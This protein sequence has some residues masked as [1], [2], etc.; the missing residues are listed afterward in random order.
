MYDVFLSYRRDSSSEFASFLCLEL[1]RL[2][3]SVFFDSQSL[4]EG[5]FEKHITAAIEECTFFLLL[6][7]PHDLD[8]CLENPESDWILKESKKAME[9]GKVF[10][11]VQVKK[12]FEFPMNTDNSIIKFISEQ[13]ICDL[14]GTHAAEKIT[15]TLLTFMNDYPAKQLTEEYNATIVTQEYIDWELDTLK[16]IYNDIEFIYAFGRHY[17]SF[18]IEGSKSITYPFTELTKEENLDT[19]KEELP[20]QEYEHFHNFRKIVGPN[21]HY[22]N[23]YGYT[24]AGYIFDNENKISSI[25]AIPRKYKETVYSCHI[26]QYELWETYKRLEGKRLATLED[27]PMRKRIHGSKNN[28]DIVLSGC[29]RSSLFDVTIAVIIYNPI[30]EEYGVASAQRSKKVATYPGYFGFV[31]SG[32]FELYELEETQTETIIKQNFSVVSALYREYIE[33]IFGDEN[34]DNPTGNDDLNRLYRNNKIK[35][36]RKGIKNKQYKFEFLGIDFDLVT[37]RQS[38]AFAIR[39][40]DEDFF[41]DNEFK[42]NNENVFLRFESLEKLENYIIKEKIPVMNETASTYYLLKNHTLFKEIVDNNFQLIE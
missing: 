6:L 24:A 4:R 30:T 32:G 5:P 28:L 10:I 7:A 3:Y 14:S 22:P 16:S 23:L 40:D 25:K 26:L 15:S 18:V 9:C 38:I 17:P 1:E 31:P 8:R 13:N 21:I 19:I 39:I 34:F 36:L 20:Y 12:G 29:N 27:M 11:P 37:L 35:G 2:G 42:K 33:E 41:Y